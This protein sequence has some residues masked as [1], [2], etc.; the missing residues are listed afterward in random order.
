MEASHNCSRIW[1]HCC[2]ISW[3][4][5]CEQRSSDRVPSG[6]W[7]KWFPISCSLI[8]TL[9][10]FAWKPLGIHYL[11]CITIWISSRITNI[12]TCNSPKLKRLRRNWQTGMFKRALT[13]HLQSIR[14]R[15]VPYIHHQ[16]QISCSLTNSC[17]IW[18]LHALWCSFY[19]VF[20]L[21]YALRK[22]YHE[23][24]R[25]ICVLYTSP[26]CGPCR[27]LKPILSKVCEERG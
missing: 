26:T 24:P 2:L 20:T 11:C 9:D 21:Q 12:I 16:I 5:S 14:D 23:S 19:V 13:L 27:T 25:L 15:Y 8:I 10:N 22:L 4:I 3:E 17:S 7:L 6:I 18:F 1:M